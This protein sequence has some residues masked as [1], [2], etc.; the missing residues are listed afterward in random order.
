MLP[1]KRVLTELIGNVYDAA[2]DETVWEVL[3]GKLAE[4]TRAESAALVVHELGQELHTLAASWMVN[5][6][7]SQLYQQHY[8]AVDVWALRGR[9]KPPGYVCTSESL[10]ELEQLANTEIYNDFLVRYGIVRGMFGVIENDPS[11]RWGSISLYRRQSSKEFGVSDLETLRFLV[12]HI[13]RSFMLHFRVSELRARA[14]G[15]ENAL[16]MLTAGVIFVGHNGDIVLMNTKAEELLRNRDGL[17]LKG[18]RLCAA[19]GAESDRLQ[20]LIS[21]AT[22][23]SNGKGMGSGGTVS[24]SRK[25]TRPLL[26]TIAPLRNVNIGLAQQSSAVLFI[27]DPDEN[28]ELPT[29]FLSRC[30]GLTRAESRLTMVLIEGRSLKEAADLCRVTHNTAK[31]QLKGI[32]SKTNVRRQAQLVR[33]ILSSPPLRQVSSE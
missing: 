17:L 24:I 2:G 27:S 20:T 9:S 18:R 4:A 7:V 10:C 28:V 15:I 16:N 6:D 1:S 11:R 12:P 29:D 21:G 30:Y 19:V 26:L 31:S 8:G 14:E 23:T 5:P 25:E 32:F 13:R 3:L 22:E 33:L